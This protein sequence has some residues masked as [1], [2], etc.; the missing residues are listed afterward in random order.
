[1]N[2][3]LKRKEIIYLLLSEK[4]NVREVTK[5]IIHLMDKEELKEAYEYHFERWTT[6]SSKYFNSIEYLPFTEDIN[7]YSYVIG[8]GDEIVYIYERDRVLEYFHETSVPFQCRELLHNTIKNIFADIS[9]LTLREPN[10]ENNLSIEVKK[11]R[12][13][14]DSRYGVLSRLINDT[15]I[16]E[17]KNKSI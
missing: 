11:F 10:L 4:I 1:M 8:S 12:D 16:G 9:E 6:V 3:P 17:K 7:Q 5:Y 2:N 13:E 14:D 15:M